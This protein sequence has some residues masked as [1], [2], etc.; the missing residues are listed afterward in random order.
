MKTSKKRGIDG[1]ES[2]LDIRFLFAFGDCATADAGC[3]AGLRT[4]AIWVI[5][6]KESCPPTMDS[7]ENSNFRR[8]NGKST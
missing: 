7:F 6:Q 4:A 1:G 5:F 2:P 8:E 3:Q